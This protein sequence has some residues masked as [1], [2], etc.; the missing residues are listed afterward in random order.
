MV[1]GGRRKHKL[2]RI[3]NYITISI[4]LLFVS[5]K[6]KNNSEAI[7]F[8]AVE[9]V[10][11]I[12]RLDT[13]IYA[14][15]ELDTSQTWFFPKTYK[16]STL[17]NSDIIEIEKQLKTCIEKYNLEQEKNYELMSKNNPQYKLDKNNYIIALK[18]YKRQLIP[19]I[20]EKG[21]K[22][23]WVNCFCDGGETYW[24]KEIVLVEDGG[25]CFFNLKINL[26]TKKYYGLMVNGVA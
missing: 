18:N 4:F 10:N 5:C 1:W 7:S 2:M 11:T 6:Q 14:I 17:T 8:P 12:L 20:N 24:Q 13:A 19:V 26:F 3:L 22:E 23:V 15:L 16:A 25:N 9:Q 21:E